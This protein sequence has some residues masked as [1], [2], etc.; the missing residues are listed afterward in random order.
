MRHFTFR[1]NH[2]SGY[3]EQRHDFFL[4]SNILQESIIKTDDLASFFA[5]HSPIFFSLY[6]EDMPTRG[7][8]FWRFNNSLTS[9]A[10]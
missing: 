10:E 4:I 5:D 1:Q 3:I 6:L 9:N 2:V 8:G 7:K